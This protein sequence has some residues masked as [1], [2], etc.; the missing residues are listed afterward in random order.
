MITVSFCASRVAVPT[1]AST[2]EPVTPLQ[3][4][5]KPLDSDVHG[6]ARARRLIAEHVALARTTELAVVLLVEQ[7]STDGGL[8][9]RLR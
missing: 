7:Q 8:V 1:C 4:S 2:N 5:R 6:R 3:R 9:V